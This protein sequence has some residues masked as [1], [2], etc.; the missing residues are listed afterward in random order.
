MP[1]VLLWPIDAPTPPPFSPGTGGSPIPPVPIGVGSNCDDA[2]LTAA[3]NAMFLDKAVGPDL[4][5]LGSMFLIPRP[6]AISNNDDVYRR[7]IEL[8]AFQPKGVLKIIYDLLGVLFGTQAQLVALGHRPWKVY[9]VVVNEIIVEI[10][11]DLV[12]ASNADATYLHGLGADHT[13][14]TGG[15]NNLFKVDGDDF[16]RAASS[17]VGL[18]LTVEIGGVLTNFTISSLTW[19]G[20][21]NTFTVTPTTLPTN[22]NGLSWRVLIPSSVSFVGDYFTASVGTPESTVDSN[23]IVLFGEGLIDVFLDLM[24]RIVKASGIKLR[25]E[26]I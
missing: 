6:S 22:T 1:V 20:T 18:T 3:R 11:L 14:Y 17:F 21:T 13:G 25:L 4:D 23:I 8:L 24:A 19:N 15:A 5:R 16:T 9:E 7:L 12:V 2:A 26:R 10:P